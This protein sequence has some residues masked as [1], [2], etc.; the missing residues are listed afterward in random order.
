MTSYTLAKRAAKLL[1]TGLAL[2]TSVS[3]AAYSTH[4]YCSFGNRVFHPEYQTQILEFEGSLAEYR[5]FKAAVMADFEAMLRKNFPIDK[6]YDGVKVRCNWY[7]RDRETTEEV[8]QIR[9]RRYVSG[10]YVDTDW[11]FGKTTITGRKIPK[12]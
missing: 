3:A 7:P 2:G 6:S 5:V 12:R 9:T 4:G 10:N 1:I 11:V 8:E